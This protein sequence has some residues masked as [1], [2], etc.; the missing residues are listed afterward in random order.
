MNSVWS[1]R[2]ASAKKV[3]S[4]SDN[5]TNGYRWSKL[6]VCRL[7][8]YTCLGA[9]TTIESYPIEHLFPFSFT[10]DE[11]DII[12]TA[13][14]ELEIKTCLQFKPRSPAD[15]QY[16]S[17]VKGKGCSSFV[18]RTFRHIQTVGWFLWCDICGFGIKQIF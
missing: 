8:T 5:Q 10:E 12:G 9:S 2:A 18:G 17:F 16:V 1:D 11:R 7:P 13:M 4:I 15:R 6:R 14:Y 3:R